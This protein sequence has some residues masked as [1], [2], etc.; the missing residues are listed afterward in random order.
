MRRIKPTYLLSFH[1]YSNLVLWPWGYTD[2]APPDARLPLV[3]K[4]LGQVSGYE[5]GQSGPTLYPTAGDDTDWAFAELGTLAYTIEVGDFND[6]F[7]PPYRDVPRLW[8][9]NLRM[10]SLILRT[11]DDPNRAAGPDMV[12]PKGPKAVAA[13]YF[14]RQPGA[15]GTGQAMEPGKAPV[16][17]S[18]GREL[19]WSHARDA[20]GNWGP[21]NITWSRPTPRR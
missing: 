15:A 20:R 21:W 18:G 19:V 16:F 1:A 10:M 9:P 3:G 17:A 2:E 11:A 7:A 4:R 14:L 12:T 5:A 13:E 8:K 6:G